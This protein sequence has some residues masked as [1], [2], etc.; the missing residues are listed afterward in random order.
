MYIGA[1][2][3]LTERRTEHFK[4]YRISEFKDRLPLYRD[5]HKYGREN[6]KFEVIEKTT[7]DNLDEREEHYIEKFNTVKNGYNIASTAHPMHCEKR[8]EFHGKFFSNWN[9]KQWQ[10]EG[11]RKQMSKQSSRV[12]RKRLKDPEYL[13]KKSAQLR[14]YTDSIKKPVGQYD[15]EGNLIAEFEGVR[16][17]ERALGLANDS[18]GKICRGVKGR[19]TAGGYVWK[20]L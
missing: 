11:Y 2:T 13:A 15:K 18:V 20:Y 4:P 19:K 5:M 8:K 3:R 10:D 9:K 12:Q 6:F 14:K 17:A 7:T 16:E 1:S